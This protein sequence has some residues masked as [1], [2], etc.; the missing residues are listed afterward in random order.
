MKTYI[1]LED[2]ASSISSSRENCSYKFMLGLTLC[3]VN[4]PPKNCRYHFWCRDARPIDRDEA[5]RLMTERLIKRSR[6][7]NRYTAPKFVALAKDILDRKHGDLLDDERVR[8][9]AATALE[10]AERTMSDIAAADRGPSVRTLG[11]PDP[12]DDAIAEMRARLAKLEAASMGD[13]A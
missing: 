5:A 11:R 9:G 3:E 2:A 8:A 7:L 6:D 4:L 1:N 13:A 10:I 12:R